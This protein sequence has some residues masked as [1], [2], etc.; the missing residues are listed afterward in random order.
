LY[1]LYIRERHVHDTLSR[2]SG[3]VCRRAR[4]KAHSALGDSGC[5]E[6]SMRWLWEG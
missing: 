4:E 1:Q 3:F 2:E 5:H 6:T